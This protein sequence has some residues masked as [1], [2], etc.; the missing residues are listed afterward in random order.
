M[1]IYDTK[2]I[3][4][5]PVPFNQPSPTCCPFLPVTIPP[6]LLGGWHSGGLWDWLSW[7]EPGKEIAGL[8]HPLTWPW[9][10][11]FVWSACAK[12]H[13]SSSNGFW[14][15]AGS[16]RHYCY[17]WVKSTDMQRDRRRR[18]VRVLHG[19]CGRAKPPSG[20]PSAPHTAQRNRRLWCG[21]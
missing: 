10:W 11:A 2:L 17:A 14:S 5:H 20:A 21:S 18:R 15:T 9:Q 16:I 12:P 8:L 6:S 7:V 3:A 4:A 19:N 1:Q 13:S